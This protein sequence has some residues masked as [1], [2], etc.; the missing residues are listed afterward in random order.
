MK[1]TYLS[2]ILI[3]ILGCTPQEN[4]IK[5][6]DKIILELN[7]ENFSVKEKEEIVEK[8]NS[9]KSK[10]PFYQK[11]DT[12]A[13]LKELSLAEEASLLDEINNKNL[14]TFTLNIWLLLVIV[15]NGL[16]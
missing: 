16:L 9:D 10:F 4:L 7:S 15:H 2:V 6:R 5:N 12:A 1:S 8:L 11:F 13:Y 3:F 14:D